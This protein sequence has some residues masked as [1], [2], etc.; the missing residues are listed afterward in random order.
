MSQSPK[1]SALDCETSILFYSILWEPSSIELAQKSL[2]VSGFL[3]N[4]SNLS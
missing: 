3:E 2:S 1:A 4:Y